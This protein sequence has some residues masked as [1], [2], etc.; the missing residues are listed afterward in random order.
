M[1]E[2]ATAEAAAWADTVIL[3]APE[4]TA[5]DVGA[6]DHVLGSFLVSEPGAG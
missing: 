4:V 2:V 6:V 3:E 1:L 5:A